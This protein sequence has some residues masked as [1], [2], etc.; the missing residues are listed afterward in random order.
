MSDDFQHRLAEV[1]DRHAQRPPEKSVAA[2]RKQG[3]RIVPFFFGIIWGALVALSARFANHNYEQFVA[4]R[5]ETPQLIYVYAGLILFVFGSI[6]VVILSVLWRLF[7]A[8]ARRRG[9]SGILGFI[10]GPA[11]SALAM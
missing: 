1:R 8:R 3:F 7:S 4:D 6:V 2:A 5:A 11:A 9:W 10:V